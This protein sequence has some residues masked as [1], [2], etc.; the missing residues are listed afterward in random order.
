MNEGMHVYSAMATSTSLNRVVVLIA[1]HISGD[2]DVDH[3]ELQEY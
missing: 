1:D 2:I 3:R